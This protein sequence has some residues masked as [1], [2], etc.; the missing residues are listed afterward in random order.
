[1][2][3]AIYVRVSRSDLNL[4]NQKIPLIQ[5]AKRNDWDYQLFQ[6]K[7]STRKTR[8]IQWDLFN[9][10]QKKEFDILLF[11]KLDRWA[12]SLPELINHVNTLTQKDV[13]VISYTENLDFNSS[14][15]KLMFHIFG[16]FAEFERDLIR[17]RTIAGLERAKAQGKKLGRPRKKRGYVKQG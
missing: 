15:G 8:P 12:R 3:C 10:L 5:Y 1:M 14:M 17:E 4:D 6:E 9:R 11:Y 7:E 13:R 16:A 2:I